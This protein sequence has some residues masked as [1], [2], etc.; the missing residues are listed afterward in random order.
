VNPVVAF[1]NRLGWS[2]RQ[3]ALVAGCA[4][5]VVA[6][7]EVGL[8]EHLPAAIFMAIARIEGRG[9]AEAQAMAYESWR[10]EEAQRLLAGA[11]A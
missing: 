3:L 10:N 8:P 6:A 11:L 5:S 2:R 9:A 4:Y 1:R 7:A